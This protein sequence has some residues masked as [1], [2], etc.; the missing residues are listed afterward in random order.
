[1]KG[2]KVGAI[3]FFG[4]VLVILAVLNMMLILRGGLNADPLNYI[5]LGVGILL[6]T[7]GVVKRR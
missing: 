5:Y 7:I 4:A 3:E 1:M 2:A 6:I